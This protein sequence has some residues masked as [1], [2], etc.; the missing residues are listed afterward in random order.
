MDAV[1]L[2]KSIRGNIYFIITYIY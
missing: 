1:S 2:L